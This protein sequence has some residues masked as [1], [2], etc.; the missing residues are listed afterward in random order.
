MKFVTI[1]LKW[2]WPSPGARKPVLPGGTQ[3]SRWCG[4]QRARELAGDERAEVA[5]VLEAR[6]DVREQ[7]RREVGSRGRRRRRRCRAT[8]ALS[9]EGRETGKHLGAA[10]SVVAVL[11]Q[12]AAVDVRRK[13]SAQDLPTA[14]AGTMRPARSSRRLGARASRAARCSASTTISSRRRHT[15]RTRSD[16]ECPGASA[17]PKIPSG[18]GAVGFVSELPERH[19]E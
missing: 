15:R 5:V 4:W 8:R 6:R 19:I 11:I 3:P 7:L 10:G 2:I 13:L 12:A 9:S 14:L 18:P 16:S 17:L 1:L